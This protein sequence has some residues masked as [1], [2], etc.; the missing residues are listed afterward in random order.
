MRSLLR[1]QM[2]DAFHPVFY[3]F[4][5]FVFW[6]GERFFL[7]YSR[8]QIQNFFLPTQSWEFI[9]NK[10][11]FSR[12]CRTHK[13]F[14]LFIKSLL[15]ISFFA[16]F[17]VFFCSLKTRDIFLPSME[18]LLNYYQQNFIDAFFKKLTVKYLFLQHTI[19]N[20]KFSKIIQNDF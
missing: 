7:P 1:T 11:Y 6:K 10:F 13:N 14:Q 5:I 9:T 17:F 18:C 16:T 8:T 12:M 2:S 20:K 3:L 19:K 4:L 15:K